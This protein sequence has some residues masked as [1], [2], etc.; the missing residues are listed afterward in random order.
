M[1]IIP[2][3]KTLLLPRKKIFEYA[4]LEALAHY[5]AESSEAGRKTAAI[6]DYALEDTLRA[7]CAD[8]HNEADIWP[9]FFKKDLHYVHSLINIPNFS[10]YFAFLFVNGCLDVA[11]EQKKCSWFV[12]RSLNPEHVRKTLIETSAKFRYCPNYDKEENMSHD[13]LVYSL[14]F[15]S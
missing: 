15:N 14:S 10:S 5:F 4:T 1:D 6:I 11:K 2:S 3:Q 8:H 7:Y 9:R 12:R 13:A